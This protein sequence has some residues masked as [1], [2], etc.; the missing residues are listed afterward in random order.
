MPKSLFR[1][2]TKH[3]A[4]ITNFIVVLLFVIGCYSEYFFSEG[5]WP[6]GLLSLALFYLLIVLIG[7]FFFWLMAKPRW[8]ILFIVTIAITQS[9]IRQIIPLRF[10]ASFTMKKADNHLRVMSW[11]A[12]QFDILHAKKQPEKQQEMVDQIKSFDPDIACIQE[13]VAGDSIV[14]THT[15]YYKRFAFIP[16]DSFAKRLGYS[17]YFYSYN[18]KE[19]FLD[20][21]HFGI[22]IFSK[23]PIINRQAISYYPHDYN[24][25]F[26]YVDI[27]KNNDTFRVFNVHLQSLRF[28]ILN[29]E[30]IDNPS[31]QSEKDIAKSKSILNKFRVGFQRRKTQADRIRIEMEKSPYP[32][33]VCGDF[34]DVPNSYPYET[35]GR[36]MKNAFA[37]KGAGLGRTFSGISPTLRIDH[38]F[39]DEH[40]TVEQF[41]R[42]PKDLSDHFAI[43]TDLSKAK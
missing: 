16:L 8:T 5:L 42:V 17:E 39:V 25:R 28:S 7:F 31:I 19:N 22:I 40:F 2:L 33:I 38:I 15:P 30:Y 24:S 35:I 34:N 37:E 9:H 26:Q 36:G 18:Y 10:S 20:Q 23:Y 11:N 43:I 6:I 13:M 21:Q 12:A 27:V 4:I 3:A 32:V 1:R 41:K 29:R 14:N